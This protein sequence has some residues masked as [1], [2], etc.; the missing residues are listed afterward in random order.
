MRHALSR[1]RPLLFRADDKSLAC[2]I[3]SRHNPRKRTHASAYA[4][5]MTG[6]AITNLGTAKSV[7]L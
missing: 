4:P 5:V 1:R 6:A 7:S 3:T 2:D